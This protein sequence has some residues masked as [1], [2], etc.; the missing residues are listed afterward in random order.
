MGTANYMSPEQARG[1]DVDARTDLWSLGVVLYEMITGTGPFVGETATDSISLIV[2][3]DPAPL[4]RYVKDVPAELER[5]ISKALTKDREER[6]QTAKDFLIDLRNLKRKLEVDAELDRTVP[7]ELR[8]PLSTA[9]GKAATR[10]YIKFV[11]YD[12]CQVPLNE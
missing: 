8:G 9:S 5:I 1:I 3:K 10:G 6:Y 12:P 2:Q 11:S 4:T 7:P